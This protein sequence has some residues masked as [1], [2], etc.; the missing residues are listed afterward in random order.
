MKMTAPKQQQQIIQD[1]R[2][3]LTRVRFTTIKSMKFYSNKPF[4]FLIFLSPLQSLIT[5]VS[6]LKL[7]ETE[8]SIT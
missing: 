6:A 1:T 5:D 8:I 7:E 2:S 3:H 4:L